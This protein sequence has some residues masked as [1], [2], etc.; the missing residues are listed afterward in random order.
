MFACI[1]TFTKSDHK[2]SKSKKQKN[3]KKNSKSN[4]MNGIGLI[5][6][7]KAIFIAKKTHD[8]NKK[9]YKIKYTNVDENKRNNSNIS[10]ISSISGDIS[11]QN[12]IF[13]QQKNI[14]NKYSDLTNKIE[15]LKQEFNVNL[16]DKD[17]E[18]DKWKQRCKILSI[19]SNGLTVDDKYK[20][21]INGN[22]QLRNSLSDVMSTPGDTKFP[23]LQYIKKLYQNIKRQYH[24]NV[25]YIIYILY[26]LCNNYVCCV[27]V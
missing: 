3:G 24:K 10:N 26:L 21:L 4:Q 16:T 19:N 20:K 15:E 27:V 11:T 18:I 2:R 25:C 13:M 23:E 9:N 14:L 7:F 17:I 12:D 22:H 5:T 8:I 6:P 1:E